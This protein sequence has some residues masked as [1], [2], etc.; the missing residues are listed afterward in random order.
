M[1]TCGE[2]PGAPEFPFQ[3]AFDGDYFAL[4]GLYDRSEKRYQKQSTIFPFKPFTYENYR[5]CYNPQDFDPDES[6]RIFVYAR[7]RLLELDVFLGKMDDARSVWQ[8]L[9]SQYEVSA[10]GYNFV[11]LAKI[12]WEAF[13]AQEDIGEACSAVQL[14]AEKNEPPYFGLILY[15]Y[16]MPVPAYDTICPFHSDEREMVTTGTFTF[17]P[18]WTGT[19]TP[20]EF[21]NFATN[22]T[23]LTQTVTANAGGNNHNGAVNHQDGD[24]PPTGRPRP[25]ACRRRKPPERR[26]HARRPHMPRLRFISKILFQTTANKFWNI[27]RAYGDRAEL[28]EQL[29]RIG[30]YEERTVNEETGKRKKF[31]FRMSRCSPKQMSLAIR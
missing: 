31:S 9:S 23:T 27:F 13:Q 26:N 16:S 15:G 19:A 22:T 11:S 29:E 1:N 30:H 5:G 7:L 2:I 4:R 14:V 10:P 18:V 8:Y 21:P 24:F 17:P 25:A 28:E 12:F 20:I 6:E 3:A